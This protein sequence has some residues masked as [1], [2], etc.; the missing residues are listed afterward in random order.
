M[1]R[2]AI[3]WGFLAVW[4]LAAPAGAQFA[5]A[6]L[7]GVVTDA[8]GG[9]LPGVTV[10]ARS[11]S[12]GTVRTSVTAGNGSYAINGL[13]PGLY[14]V[15]YSLEGFQSL[16]RSGVQLRVGQEARV[17]VTLD[18]GAVS[19]VI[20]VAG[21]SPVIEVTSKEVGGTLTAEEFESLPTQNRSALLFASLM[22]GV[23][24]SPSTESTAA[25]AIFVN[26]QDD[27][28]NGFFMDGANND[29]D[30]IG[31][32]AG[33]QTRT[34]ME[35]IQEF[36]VLTTQFD[37]EFG[38]AV[39][40]VLNALT[41]SGGN[42]FKGSVF[43]FQQD[44]SLNEEN[45]FTSRNNLEQPDTQYESSGFTVGG[46]IVTDKL[47]FFVSYEDNLNEAGVVGNFPTRPEFNFTT[48]TDN[49]IDNTLLKLD[50]QPV[51]NHHLAFRYLLEE[52]PQFNQIIPV[53]GV[54]ITLDAAREEDDTDSNWVFTVDSVVSDRAINSARVSFTKEDVS[55]ANPGFNNGGQDFDSQR[56]QDVQA[57]RP[58]FV[59]GAST[60]A[61]SRFNRST[62][63]D[64]TFSLF[65]PELRGQHE[66][67]FGF[68]Y[69]EREEEFTN[70]GTLN[71][72]FRDFSDDRPFNPNDIT[73]YPGFFNI[74]ALGGATA[75]IPNN[76]TLGIFV[77]DDWRVS[78]RLTLN[79][80]LRYDDEDITDDSNIAPRLGFAWDPKGDG[81]TVVRGGYGRF[82]DRFQL[83]FFA[84]FFLDSVNLPQGFLVRL[85]DAGSNRQLLFDIA[86]ANGATTLN[87]LR[88]VLAG[89]IESNAGAIINTQPTVD[90][91]DRKQAFVDTFSVGAEHEFWP[92]V[93]AGVDLIHSEGRDI[94]VTADLNP[95]STAQGGRPNISLLNGQPIALGSVTT[96][97]N[98]GETDYDALQLSLR[99]QFNG[100]FGGRVSLTLA[101]SDGNTE[102]GAGGTASAYFQTRTETGYNFD[103]G[104][105]LGA[106]LALNMNDPRTSGIP[107]RWHR[108]HNLVISGSYLVPKTSWRDNRGL[109]VSWIYRN[110]S[111]DQVRFFENSARID[112]GNRAL[113][114]AGS[115]QPTNPS[116]IG[117]QTSTDG[118]LRGAENPDFER[119]DLSLRYEIPV[120]SRYG[121]TLLADIFNLTD[122]TNFNGLGNT[123][124]DNRVG[125]G[126]FLTPTSAFNPQ[127][128]QI[129]VR[130]EF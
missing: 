56:S 1:R 25:D 106:P 126:T 17:N 97:L 27:N 122:E 105:L 77:Q 99:K 112:N 91:P 123:Q 31:A 66:F 109:V 90:N 19:E 30:V 100:R 92:G 9:S 130:F 94:L 72:E 69:S 62:Q 35:A 113:A 34:P 6:D 61:H 26:G 16:E 22:P 36:Q 12:A 81:K 32:R 68:Q 50:Y 38:R 75:D 86:Q 119:V 93:S 7:A 87:E 20:T 10:T 79:L 108:D 71:G 85:P 73:T 45:F 41:K 58:G 124:G 67:R 63:V 13:K 80:G 46:P 4:V 129:G 54:D 98:A 3:V 107:V 11:E 8:D 21:E 117:Q 55:F 96:Y 14:T 60:V 53:G 49:D 128:F 5:N 57:R 114:P 88:D 120:A 65:L 59:G 83:G 125:T 24:P 52:S 102:G 127:E 104:S 118:T 95:N 111:G 42:Q 37:A 51:Q 115:F 121:F 47:H 2:L 33:A 89:I 44:S 15:S 78:D 84:N 23:I 74:R 76:E 40:G 116:D 101:D 39:G 103:T 48:T 28:N 70:F 110:M 82:Y 29:D 64:D 18:L 43:F